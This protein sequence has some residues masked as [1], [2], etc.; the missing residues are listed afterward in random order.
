[1]LKIGILK[2]GVI[3]KILMIKA[4]IKITSMIATVISEKV[5]KTKTSFLALQTVYN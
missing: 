5:I 2:L 3:K 1:M 4:I